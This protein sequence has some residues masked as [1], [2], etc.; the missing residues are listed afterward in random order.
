[1]KDGRRAPKLL[2]LLVVAALGVMAF[3][4][5]A[6]AVAPGF[7]INKKPVGAL[8]ATGS[9]QQIGTGSFLVPGLNFKLSCTAYTTDEGVVESNT[10]AKMV[11]LNTGCTALLIDNSAEIDCHVTEPV[12]VEALLLPA[13]LTNGEPAVL[14][15]KIKALVTLHLKG[16]ALS[17]EVIKPCVLP[18]DNTVKGEVCVAIKNNDTAK[19][20]TF[21]DA[22]TVCKERPTLESSTEGAGFNDKL[23]YGAQPATIDGSSHI[24]LT[25]S[26]AGLTIGVSLY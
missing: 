4:A 26:H 20:L 5:S 12:Q 8:K 21:S 10:V 11:V 14:A 7:L 9:A 15:E 24:S 17:P 19:P 23:L 18:L 6:Q 16:N 1:M 22:S 2:G 25:G 13:E 3:A